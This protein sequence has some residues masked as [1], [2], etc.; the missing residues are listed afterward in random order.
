MR[1]MNGERPRDC[2][3]ESTTLSVEELGAAIR[4]SVAR[5][6]PDGVESV[7]EDRIQLADET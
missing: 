5:V 1:A 7:L 3:K 6:K 2:R 4:R